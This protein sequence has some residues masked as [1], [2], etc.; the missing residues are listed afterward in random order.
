[1]KIN[2]IMVP[3][4]N[5]IDEDLLYEMSN[6]TKKVTGIDPVIFCSQKGGAKHECRVKVSNILG[7]LTIEDTFTIEL[8]DLSVAGH[9]KLSSDQLES[10]KQ[11]IYHNRF[12]ILDYWKERID[13]GEFLNRISK[14]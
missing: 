2:E 4:N 11:W 7:K 6:L 9:C 3:T 10:A 8:K 12:A 13:T 1:M 14:I 5:P